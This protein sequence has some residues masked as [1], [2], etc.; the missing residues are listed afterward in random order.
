[1]QDRQRDK[2][3]KNKLKQRRQNK[4]IGQNISNKSSGKEYREK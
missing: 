2:C 3:R 1:M 4:M